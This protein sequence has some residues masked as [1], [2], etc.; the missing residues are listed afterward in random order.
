MARKNRRR[1]TEKDIPWVTTTLEGLDTKNYATLSRALDRDD[2]A[3]RMFCLKHG[4]KITHAHKH[5]RAR[6]P[7]TVGEVFRIAD[8]KGIRLR[9][10]AEKMGN[11]VSTI[12]AYRMGSNACS[13]F[14]L[15]CIA[16][17]VGCK[18]FV[19]EITTDGNL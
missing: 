12:G 7:T 6:A 19:E 14:A 10:I 16:D 15:E 9:D 17:I 8:A 11:N 2:H 3:V 18:I 1:F 4:I 13:V 5:K